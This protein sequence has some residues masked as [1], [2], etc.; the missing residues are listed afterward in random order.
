MGGN[1]T[2]HSITPHPQP[3]TVLPAQQAPSSQV[4]YAPPANGTPAKVSHDQPQYQPGKVPTPSVP[5]A[6]T[7]PGTVQYTVPGMTQMVSH[8]LW[9][10]SCTC[11]CEYM[12][13]RSLQYAIKS[14]K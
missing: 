8:V 13:Y 12:D 7:D 9:H 5:V 14:L 2:P 10:E 1:Q 6:G 3:S 11:F 4:M